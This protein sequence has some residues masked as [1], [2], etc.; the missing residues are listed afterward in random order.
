MSKQNKTPNDS[1]GQNPQ[2]P[3]EKSRKPGHYDKTTHKLG[4]GDLTEETIVPIVDNIPGKQSDGN[5]R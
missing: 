4:D 1:A 2:W 3:G 5:E